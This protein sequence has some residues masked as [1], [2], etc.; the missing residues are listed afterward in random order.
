MYLNPIENMWNK[1][2]QPVQG[3]G[4]G[5]QETLGNDSHAKTKLLNL[6]HTTYI[7]PPFLLPDTTRLHAF[8]YSPTP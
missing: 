6:T 3:I 1:G 4:M 7:L 2:E 5:P 8:S